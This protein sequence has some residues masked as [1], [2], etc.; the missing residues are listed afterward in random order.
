MTT[1]LDGM[2]VP[3]PDNPY[4]DR[5]PICC[6]PVQP[7]QKYTAA[8]S[9]KGGWHYAHLKCLLPKEADR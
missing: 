8:K 2:T 6:L 7:G 9:K 3:Q 4:R 5:C 1:K